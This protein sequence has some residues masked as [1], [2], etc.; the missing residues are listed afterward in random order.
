MTGSALLNTSLAPHTHTLYVF[1]RTHTHTP[2]LLFSLCYSTQLP[3]LLQV[4]YLGFSQP[5]NTVRH[6]LS[7][8]IFVVE[9]L[10]VP[11]AVLVGWW[12]G[13]SGGRGVADGVPGCV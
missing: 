8:S 12:Q 11:A 10:I 6:E 13:G 3:P 7:F 4:S 9:G 1:R 5:P 2:S